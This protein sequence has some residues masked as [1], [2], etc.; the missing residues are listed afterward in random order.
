MVE[1]PHDTSDVHPD[2]KG[3]RHAQ[4]VDLG[5]GQVT[6]DDEG[7]GGVD[8][9]TL[10][11]PGDVEDLADLFVAGSGFADHLCELRGSDLHCRQELRGRGDPVVAR[12]CS[13]RS[14]L[15][16]V[17]ECDRLLVADHRDV[18][19]GVEERPLRREV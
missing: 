14:E 10:P 7:G 19:H 4:L 13:Q 2:R 15:G 11:L 16:P 12:A 8:V 9:T 6:S 1:D 5:V 18:D 3:D 17:G